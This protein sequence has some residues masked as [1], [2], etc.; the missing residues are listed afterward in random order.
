MKADRTPLSGLWSR[1]SRGRPTLP[2]RAVEF[3]LSGWRSAPGALPRLPGIPSPG[4][5]PHRRLGRSG[6]GALG[7]P[8]V[9]PIRPWSGA[10]A[11]AGQPSGAGEEGQQVLAGQDAD[12]LAVLV[13]E[14]RVGVLEERDGLV[15]RLARADGRQRG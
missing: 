6:D 13:H 11:P 1:T 7:R 2:E 9:A 10:L 4:A 8:G 5:G 15:G 14:H 12:G 3:L